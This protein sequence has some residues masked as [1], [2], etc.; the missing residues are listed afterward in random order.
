MSTTVP[1]R[2]SPAVGQGLAGLLHLNAAFDADVSRR[3]QTEQALSQWRKAGTDA[4]RQIA[5]RLLRA[6]AADCGLFTADHPAVPVDAG[7]PNPVR[8]S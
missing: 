5:Y 8:S 4:Q 7:P 2:I 6:A 1:D 3:H